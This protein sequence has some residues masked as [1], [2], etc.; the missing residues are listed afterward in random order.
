MRPLRT[1]ELDCDG[2]RARLE[3]FFFEVLG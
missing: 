1:G 3:S 2:V